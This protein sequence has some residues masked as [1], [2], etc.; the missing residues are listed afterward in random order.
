MMEGIEYYYFSEYDHSDHYR[1][2]LYY[3]VNYG[4]TIMDQYFGTLYNEVK[5]IRLIIFRKI[6]Q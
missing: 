6:I 5:Y 2:H 3:V 4:D 1:H